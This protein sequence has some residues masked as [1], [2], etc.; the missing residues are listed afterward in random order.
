MDGWLW[1]ACS[2]YWSG[3]LL[4]IFSK[5]KWL[6]HHVMQL[7]QYTVCPN[8]L[9]KII[10]RTIILI[11]RVNFVSALTIALNRLWTVFV[12]VFGCI[13]TRWRFISVF[14]LHITSSS[15]KQK[16]QSSCNSDG[17]AITTLIIIQQL[18]SCIHKNAKHKTYSAQ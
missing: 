15:K 8:Q 6:A 9:S 12:S 16:I 3:Q 14:W 11:F 13:C 4:Q 7:T 18:T 17:E 2:Y 10:T 5:I 1:V